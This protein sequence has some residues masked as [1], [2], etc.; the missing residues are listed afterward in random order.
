MK[1]HSIRYNFLMNFILTASQF[2]F[3]IITF[4]YVSRVLTAAGNGR[5]SFA[6]SV[7]NYFI[8]VASLGIPTYGVRACAQVKNDRVLLSKTVHELFI[9]NFVVTLFTTVSFFACVCFVPKLYAEKTLFYIN[10]INILLNMFGMNW[11]YQALEQYDYITY[12]SIAFKLLSILLMFLLVHHQSDY[13][14]YCAIGVFAA[15]GSYVFNLLRLPKVINVR[16]YGDYHFKRHLKPILILFSQSLAVSIYT[17][18]DTVMLGF[19]R[20]ETDVGYYHAAVKIKMLLLSVVSSLGNVLLPRMSFYAQEKKMTE[21]V[22]TMLKALN[23]TT[24]M[25]VPL[26]TF[27]VWNAKNVIYLLAGEGYSGAVLAMQIITLAVIPNGLTCVLGV[28]VL[29]ALEKEKYVLLS[30]CVGAVTDFIL[31]L[32]LIPKFGAAGAAF[33]TMVAEYIVLI[34]QICYTYPMIRPQIKQLRFLQY[35][36][37]AFLASLALW[38]SGVLAL[39]NLFLDLCFRAA[40]F[41]GVFIFGLLLSGEP[42]VT[43]LLCKILKTIE[44][45]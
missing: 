8:M 26:T 27:F 21:L 11:L 2:L 41:F 32:L 16:W 15:V 43:E 40:V 4:P 1:Q 19:M 44:R 45:N 24:L 36:M 7:A 25:S 17:N 12:R 5:V 3:P 42:I 30:V 39:P 14:I 33:A 28:Q 35:F 10:G 31:N 20:T 29:T 13:V 18:L 34:V 22:D 37:L 9:I 23:Y 38:L 6:A